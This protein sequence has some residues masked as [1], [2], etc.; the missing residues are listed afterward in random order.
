MT[1][2]EVAGVWTEGTLEDE[3]RL[4]LYLRT[5]MRVLRHI[6][7]FNASNADEVYDEL[8]ELNWE[9]IIP[10]DGYLAVTSSVRNNTI[11]DTR[12]ANM[13]VKDAVMDRFTAETGSRP[14]SGP[15][16]DQT[17]IFIYWQ[18]EDVS[19]YIDT[20]GTPLSRRGYRK[21][22]WQ[23][24]LQE[25]LAASML[26]ASKYDGTIPLVNPMCGSGTLAIEGA[27]IAM[28]HPPGLL[29]KN[30][31][32]QHLM[33]YDPDLWERVRASAKAAVKSAPEV[34]IIA[35]DMDEEAQ[36]AAQQ[37]AYHAGVLNH[38]T[39][40]TC[41]FRDTPLPPP[42]GLVVLNPEYGERLGSKAELGE[43][44]RAIGTFFKKQ[45]P[46]YTGL[47]ISASPK[48]LKQLSLTADWKKTIYN[49]QLECRLHQYALYSS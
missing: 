2:E 8:I 5:G 30:F 19:L 40:E 10:P 7:D 49:G 46:G 14:D 37:N 22:P 25:T 6:F 35:T 47:V 28:N 12:Y 1:G 43:M 26:L 36:K 20:T 11:R 16:T 29:R 4:N 33:D 42:P 13:R 21:N 18:G 3:M 15:K 9:D 44:Y 24:P 45:C 23:A 48:L 27:W 39:W 32:F 31:G 17:V 34:D 38:I 41:D